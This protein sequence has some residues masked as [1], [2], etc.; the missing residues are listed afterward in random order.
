MIDHVLGRPSLRFRK[1]QVLAVLLFWIGVLVRGN[2][3]GPIPVFRRVSRFFTKKLTAFQVVTLT[4]L[5][6]YVAR[7]FA[8][9]LDLESPEPLANLYTRGF[10][11]TTWVLT[12]LD[13][14]FWTAMKIR[15]KWLRDIC[16]LVFSGYYLI[17]A[18]QADEKV[19]RVRATITVD[20]LR[21]SWDKVNTPY[22]KTLSSILHPRPNKY[23]PRLLRIPRPKE[24]IYKTPI[25]VWVYF[26]GPREQLKHC[27]KLVLDFPGGGFVAMNPRTH[28]D[29]LL[30]WSHNSPG[31]P[32]VSVDYRKAPEF[33]YPAGLNDCY[34]VYHSIITTRGR[35][36]G[37]S[38]HT[39]PKI[40]IAG[41]SAGGNMAAA[42]TLMILN[43]TSTSATGHL[44]ESGF[45]G[46][47]APEGLILMYPCLD[48]NMSSWISDEQY[49]LM[50]QRPANRN[51][52]RQKTAQYERTTSHASRQ[53]TKYPPP[54]HPP[55]DEDK[56][57]PTTLTTTRLAM[58]S[59]LSY[60]SDRIL[61]PE[62][63]RSMVMLYIGPSHRPSFTTDFLLSPI[64]AP[65]TLLA[66]FPRTYFL[67]G[68]RDPLV[69]DTVIFAGRI[70][71]AKEAVRRQ[72][73]EMGLE[74]EVEE[75]RVEVSLLQG[76]SHGFMVMG[77]VFPQAREEA[78]K[79]ARWIGEV[80][81][82]RPGEEVETGSSD[83]DEEEEEGEAPLEMG[84]LDKE[85]GNSVGRGPRR[86][87]VPRRKVKRMG[88][89]VSLGSH[90][91]IV[92]RRMKGLVVGL[93]QVET[94]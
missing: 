88:S 59:R 82:D 75:E 70:R 35:C 25:D 61:T 66:R 29:R 40:A 78:V 10:F 92:D 50:R 43:S 65:D 12:A 47:P 52:I 81:K 39:I 16:S 7:N 79:T 19:R 91:D 62:M 93:T 27:H 11:R 58:S 14:G 94:D 68:E 55:K 83:E 42:V 23:G 8:K 28:D 37:M 53:S 4:M 9:L 44:M 21:V 49:A 77:D 3:H 80:L 30:T 90:E 36:I 71:A 51:I 20:H 45:K 22:L 2:S 63:M 57:A 89:S 60:F 38:G 56:E 46:L 24:S 5:Y 67:T 69:D 84:G 18:E 6:L 33:P 26:E 73:G 17:A 64:V 15:K 13:A 48:L 1:I 76:I 86:K 72:R 31:I 34:D 74:V 41:D 87:K 54:P 32:I 85:T